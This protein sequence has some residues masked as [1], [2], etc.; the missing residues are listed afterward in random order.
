MGCSE[1]ITCAVSEDSH[2]K[3]FCCFVTTRTHLILVDLRQPTEPLFTVLHHLALAPVHIS[4]LH[5]SNKSASK[6][7]YIVDCHY[8]MYNA[9]SG[10]S[11][12]VLVCS[13]DSSV[14]FCYSSVSAVSVVTV[15]PHTVCLLR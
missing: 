5:S 3:P 8:C 1:A 12:L 15:V 13:C 10:P 14:V 11:S 4:C 7:I 6:D 9:I 2:L